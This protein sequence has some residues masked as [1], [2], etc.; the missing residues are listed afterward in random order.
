MSTKQV[1]IRGVFEREPGSGQWWIRFTG[2][3]GKEHR[4]FAG[5]Y[6][7]A[8]RKIED[9]RA[10]RRKG[11]APEIKGV[12]K[13]KVEP[14]AVLKFA[15][16]IKDA[17]DWSDKNND[18]VHSHELAL[19]YQKLGDLA[20]LPAADVTDDLIQTCLDKLAAEKT[21]SGS[22]Y[23]RYL[24]AVSLVFRIAIKNKKLVAS[25]VRSIRK[26]QENN[27]RVR[28]L[29]P[30][31]EVTLTAVIKKRNP[32]YLPVYLLALH[33]G[34]RLS[35]QL[36]A[37]VGD[38]DPTTGISRFTRRRCAMHRQLVMFRLRRLA[39]TPTLSWQ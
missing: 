13:K 5:K 9:R 31:E 32:E 2:A 21:W 39:L 25:P 4:E 6:T 20:K 12:P 35:E 27:A 17:R 19:K 14:V 16:L 36:R 38:F 23:N 30:Q 10:E 22:T 18:K 37:K 15:D 28:Y 34:M 7:D 1:K 33:S 3:D 8:K 29:S 24:A 26:K 11:I